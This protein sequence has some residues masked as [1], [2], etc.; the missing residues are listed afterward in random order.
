MRNK[1]KVS[2]GIKTNPEHNIPK[3]S[4]SQL[5]QFLKKSML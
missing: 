3:E 4:T 5:D 2:Q 1:V